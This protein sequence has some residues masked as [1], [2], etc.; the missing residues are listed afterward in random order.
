MNR[1]RG[2]AGRWQETTCLE[3]SRSPWA[4]KAGTSRLT[5][6]THLGMLSALEANKAWPGKEGPACVQMLSFG[7]LGP[8]YNN[9][10]FA[11]EKYSSSTDTM[12]LLIKIK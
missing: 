11:D 9:I 7:L 5:G 4:D 6:T 10:S 2:V 1:E 3:N 8:H 12:T